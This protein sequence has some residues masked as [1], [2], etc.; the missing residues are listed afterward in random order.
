MVTNNSKVNISRKG[1]KYTITATDVDPNDKEIKKALTCINF[2][3][4]EVKKV[5][6]SKSS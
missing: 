4:K 2:V 6:K 3:L 5:G 1:G